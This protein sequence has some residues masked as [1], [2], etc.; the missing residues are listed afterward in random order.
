L[1]VDRFHW[2]IER[3]QDCRTAPVRL[4]AEA[5]RALDIKD[6]S[7]FLEAVR[8][9]LVEVVHGAVPC[10]AGWSAPLRARGMNRSNHGGWPVSCCTVSACGAA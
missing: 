9:L 1:A 6:L 2:T 4:D 8:D 7:Y 5:V 10:L 3:A